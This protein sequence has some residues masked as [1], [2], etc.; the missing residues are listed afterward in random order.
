MKETPKDQLTLHIPGGL[1]VAVRE[2]A[3]CESVSL[4]PEAPVPASPFSAFFSDDLPAVPSEFPAL[5]AAFS[6]ADPR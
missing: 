6:S 4:V 5:L 2:V 1:P 3:P